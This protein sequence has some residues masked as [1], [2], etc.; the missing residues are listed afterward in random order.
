MKNV[1]IIGCGL[2]GS[3][4]VRKISKK[5]IAKRIFIYEKSKSNITKI[6]KLRLPGTIVKSLEEGLIN[7]SFVIVC[8]ST[9]EYKEL[10]IKINKTILPN[11][12]ITDVG[13]SKT[14]S[15]KVIKKFL[16]KG[17]NWIRSHPIA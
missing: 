17:I 13:S 6:K 16:K 11:T 5:K 4:L 2:I 15:S 9:S 3:S 7:S 8:T 14:E 10:I 12:L 1:L